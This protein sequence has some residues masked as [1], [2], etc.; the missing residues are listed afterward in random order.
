[1]LALSFRQP[2]A[3]LFFAPP[4][5]AK[6]IEVRSWKTAYRGELLIHASGVID[7]AD[8]KRLDVA[9][10][11]RGVLIGRVRLV[12]IERAT[13]KRWRELRNRHL[14]AGP[15]PYEKQGKKT[16]LWFFERPDLFGTPIPHLGRL[17]LFPVP[18]RV[19]P[20]GRRTRQK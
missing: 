17:G 8:C 11:P 13:A 16:H 4:R 7:R 12:K 19:L 10:A 20:A 18:D 5:S 6:T 3:N 9:P 2:W 1:M 14:C 15:R